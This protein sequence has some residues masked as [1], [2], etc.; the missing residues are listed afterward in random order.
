M[1]DIPVNQ[2]KIEDKKSSPGVN[3]F[4][5]SIAMSKKVMV[6]SLESAE[7]YVKSIRSKIKSK[8]NSIPVPHYVYNSFLKKW[9]KR[10][11]P[12]SPT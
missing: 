8:V 3:G 11:P 6:S 5:A 10:P 7:S 12:S 2:D 9:V 1:A 4:L